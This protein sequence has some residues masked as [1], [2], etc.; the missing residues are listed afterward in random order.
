MNYIHQSTTNQSLEDVATS[1]EIEGLSALPP[2]P[3]GKRLE[4]AKEEHETCLKA[5]K[6]LDRNSNSYPRQLLLH[7]SEGK[8]GNGSYKQK[9]KDDINMS[10]ERH[11]QSLHETEAQVAQ[12]WSEVKDLVNRARRITTSAAA[13]HSLA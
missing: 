9:T 13:A 11:N 7:F 1:A 4:R 10:L 12:D 5:V 8:L 3:T 6:Q 2:L